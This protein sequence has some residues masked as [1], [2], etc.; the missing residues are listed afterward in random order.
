MRVS[1]MR[2]ARQYSSPG[3]RLFMFASSSTASLGLFARPS[4]FI[5]R[6]TSALMRA[7]LSASIC[8][9]VQ[10]QVLSGL[11]GTTAPE[12]WA[13]QSDQ[14]ASAASR[15]SKVNIPARFPTCAVTGTACRLLEHPS[16]R[17]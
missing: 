2:E 9:Q 4:A 5:L 1:D 14:G 15:A 12:C 17:C 11:A 8:M 7:V 16:A 13:P 6:V 10:G 3:P